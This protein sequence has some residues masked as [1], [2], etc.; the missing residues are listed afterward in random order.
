M[1]LRAL[2]ITLLPNRKTQ[3]KQLL[4]MCL[5]IALGASSIYGQTSPL[6]GWALL[7]IGGI[8]APLA[9]VQLLPGAASLTLDQDGFHVT[10]LYRRTS[11][12][13]DEIEGFGAYSIAPKK[14]MVGFNFRPG[15][16]PK[17][18]LMRKSRDSFGYESTLGDLYGPNPEKL[19]E[20]MNAYLR[21]Q[22]VGPVA[23]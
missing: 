3:W 23:W 4:V 17:S 5:I 6:A 22:T 15:T 21:Q 8:L 18:F 14:K 2:P 13:W 19:A 7:V 16:R 10:G 12:R 1:E 20:M 9:I 11:Y